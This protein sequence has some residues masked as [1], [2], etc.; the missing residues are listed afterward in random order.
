MLLFTLVFACTQQVKEDGPTVDVHTDTQTQGTDTST[1]EDSSVP[2][3]PESSSEPTN[4]PGDTEDTSPGQDILAIIGNYY[5]NYSS[6]H[7]I[8]ETTWQIDFDTEV[9]IYDI[10]SFDNQARYVIAENSDSN[11]G[12]EVGK[13]SRF[14]WTVT[15]DNV[16]WFC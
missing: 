8:S 4:E 9:Y 11:G 16:L 10:T 14:D 3:E 15:T 1:N 13:W 12:E 7:L 6:E 2:S 5:D